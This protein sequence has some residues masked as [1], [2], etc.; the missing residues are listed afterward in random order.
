MPD[1]PTNAGQAMDEDEE[2]H[3][4]ARASLREALVRSAGD[5]APALAE[6]GWADLAEADEAFAFTALFE[7]QG[8]LGA[9]TDAL[10]A[11]VAARTGRSGAVR[12]V[13][14]SGAPHRPA[15]PGEPLEVSGVAF[16]P[17]AGSGHEVLVPWGGA[18]VAL[19]GAEVTAA[20]L[21]GMADGLR[22]VRV[23]V[24]GAAGDEVAE[25]AGVQRRARLALASELV[26]VARRILQVASDQVS[27]R[28]QFGRTIGSNQSVRFRMAESYA[29]T[30]GAASLVMAAWEDGSAD[31][32][33]W[34][35]A[36][37]ADAHDVV[38]KHA[39]QVCGAIGLSGEH[40]L[41]ALVRRG[42][43]L[44][45]VLGSSRQL[46]AA[47]ATELATTGVPEPAGRF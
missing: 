5:I 41:P 30:V 22:W 10:D 32:A 33:A 47:V 42:L 23:Q 34:A 35:K 36:V 31:T 40:P 44:D 12:V 1:R 8:A 25:W 29:E 19:D 18:L 2:L 27:T 15:G 39:M 6:F 38:A 20:P 37:A 13:W 16:G 7:E 24:R 4:M 9:D 28:R 11:A 26:G 3:A 21:G 46:R 17:V 45:A 43:A 14:P